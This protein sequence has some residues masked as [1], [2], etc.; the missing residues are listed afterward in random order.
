MGPTAPGGSGSDVRNLLLSAVSLFAVS[1]V[2][3]AFF[4]AARGMGPL[5]YAVLAVSATLLAGMF[6]SQTFGFFP[7]VSLAASLGVTRRRPASHAGR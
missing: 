4:V 6:L 3:F 7:S 1:P 2:L 5:R